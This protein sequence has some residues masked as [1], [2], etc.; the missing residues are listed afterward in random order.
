MF[1]LE[2]FSKRP[3]AAPS[4]LTTLDF[5]MNRP[6]IRKDPNLSYCPYKPCNVKRGFKGLNPLLNHIRR[7]HARQMAQERAAEVEKER[8]QR[9]DREIAERERLEGVLRRKER[10]ENRL[11]ASRQGAE[12]VLDEIYYGDDCE[13]PPS[14]TPPNRTPEPVTLRWKVSRAIDD[15]DHESDEEKGGEGKVSEEGEE[16]DWGGAEGDV[17]EEVILDLNYESD[18]DS[19]GDL[20]PPG[21]TNGVKPNGVDYF[22][23]RRKVHECV[24]KS[25]CRGKVAPENLLFDLTG[26]DKTRGPWHPFISGHDFKTARWLSRH[27]A[28]CAMI[29][30]GYNDGILAQVRSPLSFSQ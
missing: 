27:Q 17:E 23:K 24:R 1:F 20:A 11:D 30:D 12:E 25:T 18:S 15:S 13:V 16:E 21:I 19:G 26:K 10:A 28:T 7:F 8:A 5:A 4:K 6:R 3:E 22:I 2:R 29:R 14:P 9:R